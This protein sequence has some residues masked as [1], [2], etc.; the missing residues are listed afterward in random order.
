LPTTGQVLVFAKVNLGSAFALLLGVLLPRL[1]PLSL[2]SILAAACSS[3]IGSDG[4]GTEP[5]T[6]GSADA[7]PSTPPLPEPPAQIICDDGLGGLAGDLAKAMELCDGSLI[8]ATLEEVQ[9][10]QHAVVTSYG[11]AYRPQAGSAMATIA[12]G[13]ISPQED[14]DNGGTYDVS[15]SHPSPGG[16]PADGCGTADPLQVQDM[17]KLALRLKAPEGATGFQFNFNFMSAEF[18]EYLCTEF[19]DTFMAYLESQQLTGNISFDENDNVISINTGFFDVCSPQ[20]SASCQGNQDLVGTGYDDRGG[21]GWL[22]TKAPITPG[23]E[24]SLTFYLFDEGDAELTSQ[25]LIDNFKW[26]AEDLDDGPV[27]ID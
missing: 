5:D 14:K 6:A 13:G 17:V 9:G 3:Q 27:T 4:G 22:T 24:F 20:L 15:T 19:D 23:E 26:L 21:T 8:S 7:G 16:D 18:P 11:Q 25:V 2:L 1:I 10:V 12:T